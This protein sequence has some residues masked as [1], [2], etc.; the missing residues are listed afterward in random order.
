MLQV[1]PAQEM[2]N[3]CLTVSMA[4]HTILVVIAATKIKNN[5][6]TE[7]AHKGRGKD[8]KF[9]ASSRIAVPIVC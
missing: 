8:N 3:C 6:S 7:S 4:I 5:F 1:G 9:P 2:V